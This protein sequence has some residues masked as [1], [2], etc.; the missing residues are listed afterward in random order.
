MLFGPKDQT[1]SADTERHRITVFNLFYHERA[2]ESRKMN[3]IARNGLAQK[4]H[5]IG[6]A[7]V[8]VYFYKNVYLKGAFLYDYFYGRFVYTSVGIPRNIGFA[9]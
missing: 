3:E 8:A 7:F 1:V 9:V 6:C 5:P 2:G 4:A